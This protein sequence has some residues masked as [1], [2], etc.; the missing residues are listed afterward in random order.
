VSVQ[1]KLKSVGVWPEAV[2]TVH[3]YDLQ[4][5]YDYVNGRQQFLYRVSLVL[6]ARCA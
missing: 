5:E 4:P 6:G 2:R 1:A 3:Y